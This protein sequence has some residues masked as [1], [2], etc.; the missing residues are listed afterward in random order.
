ME[1]NLVIDE[2]KFGTDEFGRHTANYTNLVFQVISLDTCEKIK[3]LIRENEE[4]ES[5]IIYSSEDSKEFEVYGE[6]LNQVV[7]LAKVKI[8]GELDDDKQ[9][10]IEFDY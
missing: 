8:S 3:N 2:E 4:D 1:I 10:R 7:N 9:Y 5:L 6:L